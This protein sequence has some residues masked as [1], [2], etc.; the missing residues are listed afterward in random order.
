[1]RFLLLVLALLF[2][3]ACAHA[4]DPTL[5]ISREVSYYEIPVTPDSAPATLAVSREASYFEIPTAPD[6]VAT[7]GVSREVSAFIGYSL[8]NA[9]L[10]LRI[11]AG[12]HIASATEKQVLDLVPGTPSVIDIL[13]AVAVANRA[14]H[15]PNQ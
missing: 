1:M 9:A 12:L 5:A 11:A 3:G 13:D 7:L 14:M 10:A 15:P 8:S 6:S 2:V 4:Q